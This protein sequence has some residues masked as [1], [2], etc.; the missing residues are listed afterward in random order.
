ML[1][2]K[3]IFGR[4]RKI[5]LFVLKWSA[6]TAVCSVIVGVGS[7]HFINRWFS[8]TDGASL[9]KSTIRNQI[10]AEASIGQLTANFPRGFE[11]KDFALR[12]PAKSNLGQFEEKPSILIKRI[13][14]HVSMLSLCYGTLRIKAA[15]IDGLDIHASRT[16]GDLWISGMQK[17]LATKSPATP[18]PPE[19]E[20]N[21]EPVNP[22]LIKKILQAIVIPLRINI[23]NIGLT[24][25]SFDWTDKEKGRIKTYAKFANLSVLFDMHAWMRT[26]TISLNLTGESTTQKSQFK[27]RTQAGKKIINMDKHFT[28]GLKTTVTDY[29]QLQVT[30]FTAGLPEDTKLALMSDYNI[31][32]SSVAE[33]LHLNIGSLVKFDSEGNIQ[34]PENDFSSPSLDIRSQFHSDLSGL[35]TYVKDLGIKMSGAINV[36]KLVLK[37]RFKSN[38]V[39][40]SMILPSLEL[41]TLIEKVSVST[42]Q[43]DVDNL[44]FKIDTS[45][46][47]DQNLSESLTLHIDAMNTKMSGLPK[48]KIQSLNIDS[49]AEATNLLDP[50]NLNLPK[51]FANLRIE[52]FNVTMPDKK[53]LSLPITSNIEAK[54]EP[55]ARNFN[56]AALL[57]MGSLIQSETNASCRDN[58]SQFAV[59]SKLDIHSIEKLLALAKDFIPPSVAKDIGINAGQF[60][61][62]TDINGHMSPG[63]IDQVAKRAKGA[64]GSLVLNAILQDLN[65]SHKPTMSS[66]DGIQLHTRLA[67]EIQHQEL[68]TSLK[69]NS[70]ENPNLPKALTQSAID[71]KVIADQLAEV[72]LD[73]LNVNFPDL[74]YNLISKGHFELDESYKPKN[75]DFVV[76]TSVKPNQ[77]LQENRNLSLSKLKTSGA[78]Q[79]ELKLKT[80]DLNLVHV[81][82]GLGLDHFFVSLLSE[83]NGPALVDVKDADGFLTFSQQVNVAEILKNLP[84]NPAKANDAASSTTSTDANNTDTKSAESKDAAAKAEPKTVEESTDS[85]LSSAIDQF[86]TKAKPATAT[87][88]NAMRNESYAEIRPTRQREKPL[89]ISSIQVK[90]IKIENCEIDAEVTQNLISMNQFVCHVLDGKLQS[91]VFI[92]F[93]TT[94]RQLRFTGNATALDT[95]RLVDAFPK[96]KSQLESFSILGSSPYIDGII[97]IV[98]DVPSGDLAGGIEVTRIGKEQLKA[99]L[100]YVDPEEANPTIKTMKKA[101]LVGDLR[102]VSVPIKNGQI[103]LELDVRV[104]SVPIPIPKLQRFPLS[105]LI[106]N[107]TAKKK[108]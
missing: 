77:L 21:G 14:L 72:S 98:Y 73:H 38:P 53:M 18:P 45:F 57:Q 11:L 95:R 69:F 66:V 24:N 16:D 102:Q 48:I 25:A 65:V 52:Q 62:D 39:V 12:L 43:A 36:S 82:G 46:N 94:V 70:I 99:M 33:S 85:A 7:V 84:K 104:L 31:N 87:S 20:K 1:K 37:G 40:S 51:F 22:E 10:G 56:V 9:L 68:T 78:A 89:T 63:P 106:K 29:H 17:Y 100:L 75:V 92:T 2:L 96:L 44:N 19:P 54:V 93:D 71:L 90:D 83:V 30:G 42:P 35:N 91:S 5:F 6:I 103:G 41:H 105:Q 15:V 80:P 107:A 28:W 67:G 49:T 4:L 79:A 76:N 13:Q 88:S 108:M 3:A 64:K 61:F 101:L 86:L 32:R 97:R 26:S 59:T 50:K 58:C 23:Q 27:L 60:H 74:G 34:F 55:M 81:E 47:P 8:G